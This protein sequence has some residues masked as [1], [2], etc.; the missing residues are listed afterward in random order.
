[1]RTPILASRVCSRSLVRAMPRKCFSRKG[2]TSWTRTSPAAC[3]SI[4]RRLISCEA[5][6]CCTN[7]C[8]LT[9]RCRAIVSAL[10]ARGAAIAASS[11]SNAQCSTASTPPAATSEIAAVTT[12]AQY[13]SILRAASAPYC[14]ESISRWNASSSTASSSTRA[15]SARYRSVATRWVFGSRI[16]VAAADAEARTAPITASSPTTIIDG[17]AD[18]SRSS[19]TPGAS[20]STSRAF[21]ITKE[22]ACA[23]PRPTSAAATAYSARRSA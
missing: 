1:M 2:P 8:Q 16:P 20:S 18:R 7:R 6:T 13:T 22:A 19:M 3:W 21:T 12:A 14:A 4:S 11:G 9:Y 23:R 15:T 10:H 17:S 5:R